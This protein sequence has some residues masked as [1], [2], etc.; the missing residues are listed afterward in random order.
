MPAGFKLIISS[1]MQSHLFFLSIDDSEN[2]LSE[3]ESRSE[4]DSN[5]RALIYLSRT[6]LQ[7]I[8]A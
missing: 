5:V 4:P 1:H 8:A 6:G 3:L 2:T 7:P